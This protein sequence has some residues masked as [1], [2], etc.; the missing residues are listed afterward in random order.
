MGSRLFRL[1]LCGLIVSQ[2][3]FAQSAAKPQRP[4]EIARS[5]RF[6]SLDG[7]SAIKLEDY[8]GKVLVLGLWA[9]WCS[10]CRTLISVLEDLHKDF[11][12]RGVVVV[13]L[14]TEDPQTAGADVRRFLD[15]SGP[16]YKTG[17]ISKISGDKLLAGQDVLPQ[18]FI[19]KDGVI[20]KR[21]I[22]WDPRRTTDRLREA[23]EENVGKKP[24][25]SSF[26]R[27]RLRLVSKTVAENDLWAANNL[28]RGARQ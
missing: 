17:W 18:T 20:L 15:I 21:F 14:S 10:P 5:A 1:I 28:S 23:L 27:L 16:T 26:G 11:A 6:R 3:A 13:A 4:P 22:G 12:D 2:V 9:S 24:I 8:R 7:K 19:I 25:G